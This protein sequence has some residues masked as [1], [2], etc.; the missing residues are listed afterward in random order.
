MST[1][2]RSFRP[3]A[4]VLLLCALAAPAVSADPDADHS[5]CAGMDEPC[6]AEE[7]PCTALSAT[8]C[9]C[10]APVAAWPTAQQRESGQQ[11]VAQAPNAALD[12]PAGASIGTAPAPEP[13]VRAS[14]VRRSAVLRL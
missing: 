9:C 5:C 7:A 4:L 3:L 10:A 14:L 1:P 13:L 12:T 6:A 2:S 11:A 8:P